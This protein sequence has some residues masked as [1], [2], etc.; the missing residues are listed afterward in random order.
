M[1]DRQ[2]T[3][4][5]VGNAKSALTAI[6]RT[7][8][9]LGGL[10]KRM[11]SMGPAVGVA[12]AAILGA[13]IQF[14]RMGDEVQKM[15]L[16]TGFSTESLSELRFAA[17]QAGTDISGLET[18]IRRM[19]KSIL[20]ADRGLSTATE[21]FDRLGLSVDELKTLS[22]EKQFEV[23]S[24]ALADL[25]QQFEKSGTAQD[26]FGRAGTQL[27]PLLNEGSE[28]IQRLR[29]EARDLGIV[30]SEE[31]ANKAAAFN[32]AMNAGKQI[33]NGFAIEI[34]STFA[35]AITTLVRGFQALPQPIQRVT[36]TAG[37][38]FAAMKFGL[39]SVKTAFISTGI[40]ALIIGLSEALR[41]GA[42]AFGLFGDGLTE[43][44]K[45]AAGYVEQVREFIEQTK[46]LDDVMSSWMVTL[47]GTNRLLNIS[48]DAAKRFIQLV[49]QGVPPVLALSQ[50]I[51]EEEAAL[52]AMRLEARLA[53]AAE[54]ELGENAGLAARD[55]AQLSS[56]AIATAFALR[57]F[58]AQASGS[59]LEIV[60]LIGQIGGM[61]EQL[62][63]AIATERGIEAL[64]DA[65]LGFAGG[66]DIASESA[67]SFAGS[68]DEVAEAQN[69]AKKASEE[70]Q[71]QQLGA[72]RAAQSELQKMIAEW[73]RLQGLAE[74]GVVAFNPATGTFVPVGTP[75]GTQGAFV[76]QGRVFGPDLQQ[77]PIGAR[78][79]AAGEVILPPGAPTAGETAVAGQNID[80][81]FFGTTLNI[82]VAGLSIEEIVAIV[83]A[84]MDVRGAA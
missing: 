5:I 34:G 77:L 44:E 14:A 23:I 26:I 78:V 40:G 3:L 56:R 9:R 73:E 59:G 52:E 67:S 58:Q 62:R 55:L 71:A 72:L 7:G 74:S 12:G 28:G 24:L 18:G 70:W 76:N 75:I 17:Q 68:V 66:T 51:A 11:R 21:A 47:R 4:T 80:A 33:V 65:M 30:F 27:L 15:S 83:I 60:N 43:A 50:A 32:D 1:A 36:I 37:I 54:A 6:D 2:L 61:N 20:D 42:T 57:I 25:S 49:D 10:E 64:V 84:R 16:R 8:R 31:A 63:K 53:A 13:T 45:N 41:I 29:Q 82:N 35:P 48:G 38:F 69:R 22:P 81:D 46:G 19:Q 79:T 39:I